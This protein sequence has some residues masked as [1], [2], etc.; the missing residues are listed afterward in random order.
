MSADILG[1]PMHLCPTPSSAG[2]EVCT[3]QTFGAFPKFSLIIYQKMLFSSSVI[4]E[5]P[6]ANAKQINRINISRCQNQP[7]TKV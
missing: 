4:Q 7:E 2:K 1:W 6:F 3:V 5:I